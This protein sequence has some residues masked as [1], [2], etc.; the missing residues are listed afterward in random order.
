MP[1]MPDLW[2]AAHLI[3]QLDDYKEKSEKVLLS[4]Q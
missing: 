2:W 3:G 1:V 4:N